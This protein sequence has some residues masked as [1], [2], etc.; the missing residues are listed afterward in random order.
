MEN[1]YGGNEGVQ[2]SSPIE[3]ACCGALDAHGEACGL[4]HHLR[5]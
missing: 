5:V 3:E 4:A 2:A 1:A